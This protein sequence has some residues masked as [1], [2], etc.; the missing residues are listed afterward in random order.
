MTIVFMVV[1]AILGA[2]IVISYGEM[3]YHQGC[4]SGLRQGEAICQKYHSV[5]NY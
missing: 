3:R 2:V 1:L 5:E 4:L